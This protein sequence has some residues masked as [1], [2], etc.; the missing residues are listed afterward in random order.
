MGYALVGMFLSDKAEQAFGLE[1][2]QADKER[3]QQS[4][5]RIQIVD[6]ER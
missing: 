4:I 1:P 3:L 2:T 6:K 5:P